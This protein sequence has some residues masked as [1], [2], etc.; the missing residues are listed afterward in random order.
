M[1]YF[2]DQFHQEL[3]RLGGGHNAHL[4]LD[5]AHTLEDGYVDAGR[6]RVLESSS[7]SLKSKHALLATVHEGRAFTDDDMR[8][9]LDRVIRELL[10]ANTRCA[11][12]MVDVTNDCVQ[13]S[14]LDRVQDVARAWAGQITIRAAA[15]TPLGFRRGDNAT[16]DLF[17]RGVAQAEF[18]G[19]LP[20]A[21]DLDDYPDHIGF[22]E[23]C[24]RMLD[25]SRRSGKMLHVHTDQRNEPGERGTE[26]LIETM[27]RDGPL[28]DAD[29]AP[30]VW[31]V[32]AVSPS[33]YD[34]ERFRAFVDGLLECN[35][36]IICCPSAAIGMRQLRPVQTPAYNSIPRVL[37]LAEAG[38]HLRLG[39]DNI[40]DICSP[41]TTADLRDEVLVLSAAVR[42]FQPRILAKL[43]AGVLLD[44]A[45]RAELAEHLAANGKE[46]AKVVGASV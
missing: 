19:S 45:D 6:V 14:A 36:G 27:R 46:I 23:H 38:V 4:H 24:A 30:L 16:W 7:I 35:I 8:A 21:D 12:T 26:R 10:A 44:Q 15:Y 9:R 13:L 20:E 33:T 41:S 18:I 29:G 1:S 43:A 37:E 3:S 34:E 17:E 40:A 28:A 2:F 42:Y 22:E 5:R 11:D 39:S 25:L 31:A 32:H